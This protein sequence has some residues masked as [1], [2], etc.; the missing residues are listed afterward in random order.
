MNTFSRARLVDARR[1]SS[2]NLVTFEIGHK[3]WCEFAPFANLCFSKNPIRAPLS[4][5]DPR[6]HQRTSRHSRYFSREGGPVQQQTART[7][8]RGGYRWRHTL[9]AD[10]RT[11]ELN[12]RRVPVRPLSV[13]APHVIQLQYRPAVW[14]RPRIV[15]G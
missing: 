11:A 8:R 15:V 4:Q 14:K 5:R 7:L 1:L 9:L 3:T 6:K 10:I 12:W 2:I 13:S